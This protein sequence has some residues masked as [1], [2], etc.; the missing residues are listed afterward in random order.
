MATQRR[1]RLTDSADSQ[2]DP[3]PMKR[4]RLNTDLDFLTASDAE[5]RYI[6]FTLL[7]LISQVGGTGPQF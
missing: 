3:S 5:A 1:A 6:H 2:M 7:S 4:R